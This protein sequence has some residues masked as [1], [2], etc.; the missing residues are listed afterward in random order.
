MKRFMRDVVIY[1][2]GTVVTGYLETL[3]RNGSAQRRAA[4]AR[5]ALAE[6][7]LRIEGLFRAVTP[8][9]RRRRTSAEIIAAQVLGR[10]SGW[11]PF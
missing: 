10:R 8:F 6:K 2:A 3:A 9:N 1:T 7:D 11:K 5:A 4:W